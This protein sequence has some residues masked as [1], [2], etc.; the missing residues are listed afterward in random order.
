MSPRSCATSPGRGRTVE[1]V[2][3]A[4][5]RAPAATEV[6]GMRRARRD[7][8]LVAAGIQLEDLSPL[9][10]GALDFLAGQCGRYYDGF[11]EVIL[12]ARGRCSDLDPAPSRPPSGP[13]L[14]YRG[15]GRTKPRRNLPPQP[16]SAGP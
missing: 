1:G 5:D 4:K 10:V 13:S 14:D 16:G 11:V 15:V 6:A 8:L 2:G 3:M 7:G 12:V 9:A